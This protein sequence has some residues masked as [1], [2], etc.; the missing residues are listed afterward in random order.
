MIENSVSKEKPLNR[1]AY[2]SIG[3]L[4]GSR[5]G[6]GDHH[7]SGG[8]AKICLEKKRDKFDNIVIQEKLDGVCMAVAKIKGEIIPLNRIG[9]TA[10]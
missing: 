4:P 1:K 3:H 10:L 2:G 7:I 5:M 8:Q 6:K 9:Y